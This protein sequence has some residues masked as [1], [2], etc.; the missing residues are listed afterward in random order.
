MKMKK[1]VKP[2]YRKVNT[3]ARNVHHNTGGDARHDRHTK[4]G[5]SK[6]MKQGK[7]R[8]LD[9][10]PLHMFL[11]SKVGKDWDVV[12][13]EARARLDREAPIYWMVALHECDRKETVRIG[14]SSIYSGLYVDENNVLQKVN[15]NLHVGIFTPSCPCCTHTFNGKPFIKKF[16]PFSGPLKEGERYF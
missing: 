10:A 13:S 16:I 4:K 1:E 15:P 14:E 6:S 2:L 12:F 11:L 5:L 7:E 8:G 3:R 9:Y